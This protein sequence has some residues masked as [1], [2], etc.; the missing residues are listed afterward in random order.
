MFTF[1]PQNLDS[2]LPHK[3]QAG[4]GLSQIWC[5]NFVLIRQ[6]ERGGTSLNAG[7]ERW[8]KRDRQPTGTG[9]PP[10]GFGSP[11]L[12]NTVCHWVL[13]PN[14]FVRILRGPLAVAL[15]LVLPNPLSPFLV[16]RRHI[17]KLETKVPRARKLRSFGLRPRNH[18][19]ATPPRLTPLPK[20]FGA[21]GSCSRGTA[22]LAANVCS[23]GGNEEES[24]REK[25]HLRSR[26]TRVAISSATGH[27]LSH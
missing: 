23:I 12:E 2:V 6:G 14:I 15:S 26:N 4:K 22:Y 19:S 1:L 17:P 8:E 18:G 20:T 13:G 5:L 9:N 3:A 25:F 24:G 16:T 27:F 11:P 10:E 21:N 7:L